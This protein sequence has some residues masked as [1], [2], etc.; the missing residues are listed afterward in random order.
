MAKNSCFL[1]SEFFKF[2]PPLKAEKAVM[3]EE[4]KVQAAKAAQPKR[5]SVGFAAEVDVENDEDKNEPKDEN[6]YLPEAKP[7]P[8]LKTP[9]TFDEALQEEFIIF[10]SF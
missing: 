10:L 1:I 5:K 9:T 2:K 6:Q 8:I 4:R 7:K 3:S